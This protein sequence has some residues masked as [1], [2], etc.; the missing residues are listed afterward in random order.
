MQQ[1]VV[2]YGV[3]EGQILA[4][5]LENRKRFEGMITVR[6]PELKHVVLFHEKVAVLWLVK[7]PCT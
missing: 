5:L 1:M 6:S 2:R 7:H 4:H 3:T